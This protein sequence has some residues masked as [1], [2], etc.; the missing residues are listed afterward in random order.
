MFETELPLP[1]H[2]RAHVD[3]E[4]QTVTTNADQTRNKACLDARFEVQMVSASQAICC[5]SCEAPH[6]ILCCR[7]L[8]V[9]F[10]FFFFFF[11]F[12]VLLLFAR[13]LMEDKEVAYVPAA[14]GIRPWSLG[15]S[16]ARPGP[17]DVTEGS[18]KVGK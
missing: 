13:L 18:K 12:F 11:F 6:M 3:R 17:P 5:P 9:V 15:S 4:S 7:L 16:V 8:L 14:G 1:L 10:F 2:L